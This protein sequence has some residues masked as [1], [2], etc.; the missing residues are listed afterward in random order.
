MKALLKTNVK[1]KQV[2]YQA[3]SSFLPFNSPT[4]TLP[5]SHKK[6]KYFPLLENL[7]QF[8][9]DGLAASKIPSQKTTAAES[10][11]SDILNIPLLVVWV[12]VTRCLMRY[13]P[14]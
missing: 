8:C 1:I 10:V 12:L 11:P 7:K 9:K 5:K 14:A 4:E 13:F 3:Q 2:H 6:L